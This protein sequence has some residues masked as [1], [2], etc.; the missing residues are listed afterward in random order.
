VTSEDRWA[1]F[2]AVRVVVWITATVL[3]ILFGWLASVTFVAACSLYANIASDFAAFRADR[4]TEI[5]DRLDRIE[6]IVRAHST[7]EK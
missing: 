4:N 5:L 7:K 3:A 6:A 2:S 1:A